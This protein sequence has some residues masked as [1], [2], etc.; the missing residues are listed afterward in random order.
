[1]EL[2]APIV[3]ESTAQFRQHSMIISPE[4]LSHR[5]SAKNRGRLTLQILARP[6]NSEFAIM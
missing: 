5:L 4:G 6:K 2:L 3:S 1:M